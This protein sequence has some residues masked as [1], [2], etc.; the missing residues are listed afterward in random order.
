MSLTARQS[1]VA[2]PLL[3]NPEYADQ[4]SSDKHFRKGGVADVRFG[5]AGCALPV[6]LNHNTPNN[7]VFLLWGPEM[8]KFPGLFPRASRHRET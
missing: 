3:D 4:S 6:V 5:F 1:S 7:S 8:S 2:K